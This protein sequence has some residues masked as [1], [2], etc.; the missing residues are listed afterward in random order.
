[1]TILDV[2][3]ALSGVATAI[4]VGVAA[5]QLFIT[6]EQAAKSFEDSLTSQY[7]NAI[8]KLPVEVL[9]GETLKPEIQTVSIPHFYRYFDLCNEQVFLRSMGR[10]TD[11]TWTNWEDGIKTNLTRPA[12]ALA[13]SEVAYR[14]KED[15]EDLRALCPPEVWRQ[16][17]NHASR[18]AI[19]PV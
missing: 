11:S 13:W 12:F 19:S 6:R 3:S 16:A 14:A 7:R 10:V 4:G 2:L 1:M 15:F 8:E 9:F 5:R 18:A 17:E